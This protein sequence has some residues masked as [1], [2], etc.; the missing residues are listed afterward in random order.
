MND[1]SAYLDDQV[2]ARLRQDFLA[3]ARD[4]LD[5]MESAA[6]FAAGS[7]PADGAQA[8]LAIRREAHNLKGL[9]ASFGFP[10][11]TMIAHR[12][13]DFAAELSTLSGRYVSDALKFVDCMRDIVDRGR[14]P[15]DRRVG[16]I[17]RALPAHASPEFEVGESRQIEILLL[18]PSQTLRRML[19][20]ELRA[21]GGRV[22]TVQS[23]WQW[24]EMAAR[25]APDLVISSAIIDQVSGIDMAC[26]L[27]AMSVTE[28]L[29]IALVTSLGDDHPDLKRLPND[30]AIVRLGRSLSEDLGDAVTRL[31][32]G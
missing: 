21:L 10:A 32:L 5:S 8:L 23:P 27:R 6:E 7:A 31:A 17:M 25:T 22:S 1:A 16:E 29:P 3:D 30:V 4:R 9:G 28:R 14:D 12:L 13:E 11:L 24:L 19:S 2:I 26:A 20:A 18:V 15:D